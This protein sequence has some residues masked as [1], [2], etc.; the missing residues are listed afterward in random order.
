MTSSPDSAIPTDTKDWT[1]VLEHPCP[2][3][4][5]DASTVEFGSIAGQVRAMTPLWQERLGRAD[6][7][8]RP[9]PQVWSPTEYAAHVRDVHRVFAGRFAQL[10]T[11]DDPLFAN[12]DQDAA[13]IEGDYASLPPGQVGRELASA[14]EEIASQ[15]ELVGADQLDR[16]GRRSNGSVFTV[17]SLGRYYLHDLVHH[18][19][20]VERP[21][22]D[23]DD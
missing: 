1:W 15:L 10:L 18:L 16:P 6:A 7:R 9:T 23:F 4:G 13:A 22:Q 2:D 11:Q 8:T 5:F 17:D 14:A 12:W 3:C 21:R 20:D 19:Y